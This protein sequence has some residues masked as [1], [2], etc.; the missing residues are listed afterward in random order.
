MKMADAYSND[1]HDLGQALDELAPMTSA[2][3]AAEQK[4]KLQALIRQFKVYQWMQMKN[5]HINFE[6]FSGRNRLSV[7]IYNI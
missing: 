4:Q 3:E 2:E 1:L 7:I 6:K 5:T